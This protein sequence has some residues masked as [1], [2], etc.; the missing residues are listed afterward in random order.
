MSNIYY[1]AY[2]FEKKWNPGQ[3]FSCKMSESKEATKYEVCFVQTNDDSNDPSENM[4]LAYEAMDS[5]QLEPTWVTPSECL[6]VLKKE[7]K[8]YVIDPFE[9]EIFQHLK[10]KN[11]RIVGPLCI[12]YCLRNGDILPKRPHPVYSVSMRKIT[13]SCSNIDHATRESIK[14]QVEQMGGFFSKDLTKSVTHLIIGEVGSKKYRVA[15]NFGLSIMMPSWVEEV[16]KN[17]QYQQLHATDSSFNKYKCPVFKGLVI[18]V[19]QMSVD[20]R[21]AI[22]TIIEENGGTYLAPLKASKTT[23]L[24]LC[25]PSGD[26]YKYA[27]MWKIYCVNV[28]WIY[29]SVK[30]GYCKD[31]T[32][33]KIDDSSK[34]TQPKRSTPNRDLTSCDLPLVD[35]SAI[36]NVSMVTQLDETVKSEISIV[37]RKTSWVPV[38][39]SF[40]LS[41]LPKYG[42]FLDG[43]KIFLTGFSST[44]LDKLRK[45]VNAGGG[46]RF[47]K[48]SESISH[49]VCGDLTED[50]LQSH[51]SSSVKPY[52]VNLNWLLECCKNEK[53]VDEK[54]Y[55]CMDSTMLSPEKEAPVSM[56]QNLKSI[57]LSKNVKPITVSQS[58][59]SQSKKDPSSPCENLTE[60]FKQYVCENN[61]NK[62]LNKSDQNRKSLKESNKEFTTE[63]KPRSGETNNSIKQEID[64]IDLV[65]DEPTSSSVQLYAGLK[66]SIV[67]FGEKDS[68]LFAKMIE[69]HSGS[70][71][72]N[73]PAFN[74]D[75]AIVPLIWNDYAIHAANIITN[76]WLQKCIEDSRIYEFDENE[77]FRPIHIPSDRKPFESFVISVSQYSGTE[78]DCLMYLS[79][80]LG[81]TVQEYFVRKANRARGILSNTHLIAA[82]PEGSKYEAAKKWKIP[83][84]TK[85]WVLDAAKSGVAPS[86]DKYLVD[87]CASSEVNNDIVY[88]PIIPEKAIE[89]EN[90]KPDEIE[91]ICIDPPNIAQ[92]RKSLAKS[93]Q[94]NERKIVVDISN[95]GANE[96]NLIKLDSG[97]D[98]EFAKPLNAICTSTPQRSLK[99]LHD[100]KELSPMVSRTESTFNESL[101]L[102]RSYKYKFQV[103][104]L[105]KDLDASATQE[106]S[107]TASAKRKSL[108]VEELFGRNL[109]SAIRG[110][111]NKVLFPNGGKLDFDGNS[112]TENPST[113]ATN[114]VMKG[115]ILCVSKKLADMQNEL[116]EIV[117]SMGGD[118]Q[119][120]YDGSCT[121]FVFTGKA[122]DLSKEFREARAQGKKIVCPE[123]V[124]ACK[125]NNVIVD[126][127]L[128]PHTLKMNMSLAGDI[129]IVKHA[130]TN[131]VNVKTESQKP[132]DKDIIFIGEDVVDFNQQ[133]NDLLVAAKS[134]KKR[135]SKR[136]LNSISNS[137]VNEANHI[138][139]LQQKHLSDSCIKSDHQEENGTCEE[140]DTGSQSQTY[141][142]VWDDPTG[143]Q[144][145]EKIAALTAASEAE[146]NKQKEGP[147]TD[148]SKMMRIKSD[149]SNA[150]KD[151]LGEDNPLNE[152]FLGP[153]KKSLNPQNQIKIKKFMFTNIP[154]PKKMKFVEIIKTLGGEVSDEKAFDISSTHLILEKPIKNEKLLSSIAS[155]KW[156]LHPQYF[157]ACE[158]QM[159]FVPEE[160]FEWGGP[161]TEEFLQNL[162]NSCKKMA[163][164][165]FRWRVK[166]NIQ[167]SLK[168]A[169]NDWVVLV[170]ADDKAKQLTYTKI[171]EAG[172][173]E[174]L[175]SEMSNHDLERL[176]YVI[177]DMK[178][179]S[180][181]Q[182][183]L[184]PYISNKIKCVKP[185]YLA[186]FLIED[187]APDIEN[188]IIPEAQNLSDT[189]Q[190]SKRRTLSIVTRGSKRT[191]LTL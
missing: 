168:G 5:S 157:T 175:S 98:S 124:Y 181:S 174:V 105:L 103:S 28:N 185:E 42:Q 45:I 46:M 60:I 11:C 191:K 65:D 78:R 108:P 27:K 128:Y 21:S 86:V 23:H 20:E 126:E 167:T 111:N 188:F 6:K 94:E 169:F 178:K 151:T 186:F 13:V 139:K 143:R 10:S 55:L 64:V 144:E 135:N 61:D 113:S 51:K 190:S 150:Q 106:H 165:P 43:C 29:E 142:V 129:A 183:D 141:P 57:S 14:D 122:N 58:S 161:F 137:P 134:A 56:S 163:Y 31:E 119:W 109:A 154:E 184:S 30:S 166:L 7:P 84:V 67:G 102:D 100:K 99:E 50:I 162:P 136:L 182:I 152:I 160:D 52:V 72:N 26:K 179:R 115:I 112:F 116:N 149:F 107:I 164:C 101:N 12:L 62:D 80:N 17:G 47:N 159:K 24:V 170:I 133:L 153:K 37:T 76:C 32:L 125:E 33:Y 148:L 16:W 75:I 69:F 36:T 92:T 89:V 189:D 44:H 171:L 145:R 4:K 15:A 91:E 70:V 172:G 68:E 173:A 146:K 96:V 120:T 3:N 35:C 87:V 114:T 41:S 93:R 73:D 155:G 1:G 8:L 97:V 18:T 74:V 63:S 118:Y 81:A 140:Q 66:F 49:V 132:Q 104:G 71:Y 79:E 39:E 176:S 123:W 77:L 83:A 90:V 22:Q 117:A 82:T 48:Y 158:E 40:D 9:G 19:S 54:P 88:N 59:I 147:S 177:V 85:Q 2:K 156:V 131:D 25:E 38:L 187:P 34:N 130:T 53:L 121:H 138:H 110:V 180:L 95:S 127:E